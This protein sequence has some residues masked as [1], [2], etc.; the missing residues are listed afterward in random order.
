MGRPAE[1]ADLYLGLVMDEPENGN[2][3]L[4]LSRA[5]SLSGEPDLATTE[6]AA[7]RALTSGEPVHDPLSWAER[8]ADRFR[9][10]DLAAAYFEFLA[11][12][13]IRTYSLPGGGLVEVWFFLRQGRVM[14]FREGAFLA[15]PLILPES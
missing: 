6:E 12:D 8:A 1:A 2:Y 11:P 5:H 14:A 13:V 7:G 4:A 15:P 10:S 9:R 3:Y